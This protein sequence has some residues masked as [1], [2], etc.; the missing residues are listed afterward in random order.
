M[1]DNLSFEDQVES[2]IGKRVHWIDTKEMSQLKELFRIFHTNFEN[3]YN[4]LLR[5]SLIKEDLYKYEQK[6]SDIV[7]PPADSFLESEKMDQISNRLSNFDSQLEFLNNYYQFNIEFLDLPHIR[8]LVKL[9]NYIKWGR[10]SD[11]SSNI[12]TRV[13]GEMTGK[14]KAGGDTLSSGIVKDAQN[15]LEKISNEIL[16]IL[17]SVATL[18]KERYKFVI[19]KTVFRGLQINNTTYELDPESVLRQV[20]KA[21]APIAE[22]TPFYTELIQEILAEDLSANSKGLR[23]KVLKNLYFEE[24]K[25]KE[26]KTVSYKTILLDAVRTLGGANLHMEQAYRKL[27][28]NSLLLKQRKLS[29]GEKIKRWIIG[30]GNKQDSKLTL[31]LEFFDDISPT[32]RTIKLN[33]TGFTENLSKRNRVL[34]AF[35]N[36]MSSA[37]LK[38]EGV[39]EEQ[40]YKVLESNLKEV[41][42]ILLLLP[43]VDTYFKAEVPHERRNQV[44]GIKIEING[45]KNSVVKTN[46]KMHEYVARKEESEQLKRLGIDSTTS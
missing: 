27:L 16:K 37:Y 40:I 5:K 24:K 22:H 6:S 9:I 2:A 1:E 36:K 28:A 11:L 19:R 14:I 4:L 3:I 42:E 21:F 39:P 35:A 7:I 46:Q 31:D 8:L 44:R 10:L 33:F 43:P 12:N 15:Q 29:L 20:K 25:E 17:K 18:Q 45:I 41:R 13:L 34:T 30:A 26:E 32:A 23:E 38:L